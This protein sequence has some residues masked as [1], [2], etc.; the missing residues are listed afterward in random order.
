MKLLRSWTKFL[1]DRS[2]QHHWIIRA[3]CAEE[4]VDFV[5]KNLKL[6]NE[7][8]FYHSDYVYCRRWK[9]KGYEITQLGWGDV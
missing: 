1:S 2:W 8:R 7:A 3:T 5:E 9:D 6:V 4:A